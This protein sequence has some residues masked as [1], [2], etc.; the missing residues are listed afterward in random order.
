MLLNI[1]YS[2]GQPPQQRIIW[3]QKTIVPQWRD[4]KLVLGNVNF[5]CRYYLP[6]FMFQQSQAVANAPLPYGFVLSQYLCFILQDVYKIFI[7]L[8]QI[9]IVAHGIFNLYCSMWHL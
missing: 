8:H 7:W 4:L 6:Y 1:L 9:L 2:T 5:I 3:P